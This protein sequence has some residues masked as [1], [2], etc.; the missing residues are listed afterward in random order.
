[1][2]KLP[3]GF[4]QCVGQGAECN[5]RTPTER[6]QHIQAHV[7]EGWRSEALLYALTMWRKK[8]QSLDSL[9]SS[10]SQEL[11][12]PDDQT[13][14]EE[15]EEEE[16]EDDAFGIC[17][18]TTESKCEELYEQGMLLKTQGQLDTALACFVDSLKR[19][20]ECHFFAKLP[21][22]LHELAE[23]YHTMER[24][25]KAV[26]FA[27]AEKLFYE[28]VLI[29]Y[30]G[31]KRDGKGNHGTAQGCSDPANYGDL[32]VKKASEFEE[33]SRLCARDKNFQ[34]ALDY[35]GKAAKI[36]Q[37]VFGQE[38]PSTVA[39]LEYFTELYAEVG[40]MQ[41]ATAVHRMS[42][43]SENVSSPLEE[44]VAKIGEE[45]SSSA[46]KGTDNRERP[47]GEENSQNVNNQAQ[48]VSIRKPSHTE[49]DGPMDS[50]SPATVDNRE[51][52][53]NVRGEQEAW[54]F[55]ERLVYYRAPLWLI[56]VAAVVMIGLTFA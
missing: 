39:T 3:R 5:T 31:G 50:P 51:P 42:E 44:T 1:M 49:T 2:S 35:C 54:S 48:P 40:R 25:D 43:R 10:V 34:L 20:Q 19:M 28:A 8:A 14:H 15:D 52:V 30:H 22:T 27:Q 21:H 18:T 32:L 12:Q 29:D 13:L 55:F 33:L 47:E 24:Y 53:K 45:T 38:H 23:L 4:P 37:S 26:E 17:F 11:A 9:G 46:E 16:L 56:I 41:Y 7:H 6:P 36:R